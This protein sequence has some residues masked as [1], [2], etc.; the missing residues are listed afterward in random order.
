[1]SISSNTPGHT[2]QCRSPWDGRWSVPSMSPTRG[3]GAASFEETRDRPLDPAVVA[4]AEAL[5]ARYPI[6][7]RRDANGYANGY[8]GEVAAMPGVFGHGTSEAVA[9]DTTRDLLKWA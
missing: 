5:A 8:A 6:R 9:L 2:G 1:M 7:V 4:E 3:N